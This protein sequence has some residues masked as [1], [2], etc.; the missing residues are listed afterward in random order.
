MGS[1]RARRSSRFAI[2]TARSDPTS[3]VSVPICEQSNGDKV[4][5]FNPESY[6]VTAVNYHAHL[7]GSEMYTTLLS[8][9]TETNLDAMHQQIP[10]STSMAKDLKSRDIRLHNFLRFRYC[11]R[12]YTDAGNG[13]QSWGQDPGQL[14]L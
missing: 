14:R 8:E 2:W 9:E 12:Q 6:R 1:S 11:Q 4:N 5:P 3:S 7:L 10:V 13:N